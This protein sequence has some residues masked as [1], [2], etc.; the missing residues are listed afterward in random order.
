MSNMRAVV[1][2]KP[3][4]VSVQEVAKPTILHPNDV[5]VKGANSTYNLA[6]RNSLFTLDAVTT[7]CIC[8]RYAFCAPSDKLEI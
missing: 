6:H 8:G 2:D 5:I 3:F 1:Y 4:S 7:T